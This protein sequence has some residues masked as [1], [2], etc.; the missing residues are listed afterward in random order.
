VPLS[1]YGETKLAG[2]IAAREVLPD[3]HL[4]VRTQWLFGA[5]GPNFITAVLRRAKERGW[6][7]V[8]TDEMGA[9]TYARDLASAFV[10]LIACEAR[11]TFHV[12]NAGA[13]TRFEVARYA[14]AR[15][16]LT[17]DLQPCTTDQLQPRPAAT[18]PAYS[19]FDCSRFIAL[20]GRPLP[21]W[22]EAVDAFLGEGT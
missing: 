14:L 16:G 9:P 5:G 17:V 18:R 2:E 12:A 1:H 7:R 6:L 20:A 10:R 13:A 11:G 3:A 15:A 22:Q 21:P 19:V 4:I 8:V